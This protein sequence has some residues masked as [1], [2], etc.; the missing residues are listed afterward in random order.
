M[1]YFSKPVNLR[2]FDNLNKKMKRAGSRPTEY[3]P[4]FAD[5]EQGV[6]IMEKMLG[7]NQTD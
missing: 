7:I 1:R 6:D 4:T 3:Y 5:M 2:D